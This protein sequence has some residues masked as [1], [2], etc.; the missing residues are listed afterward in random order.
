MNVGV[1]GGRAAQ[2]ARAPQNAAPRG[3]AKASAKRRG[4]REYTQKSLFGQ[5][6]LIG[7]S[8][9]ACDNEDRHP[10]HLISRKGETRTREEV[11]FGTL[12]VCG[13]MDYKIDDVCELIKVS[14]MNILCIN[15]TSG[16]VIKHGSF[17]TYQCGVDQSQQGC[18]SA[19]FILT[20]R[21][22]KCVHSHE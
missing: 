12:N 17:E 11:R 16:G 5:S 3:N 20:E 8:R 6:R 9:L 1:G 21:L 14:Q 18:R 22:S 15:K 19:S 10:S 4:L 7:S 13:G 2:G